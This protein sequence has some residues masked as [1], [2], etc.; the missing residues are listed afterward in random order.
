MSEKIFKSKVPSLHYMLGT[1]QFVIQQHAG[2]DT[3]RGGG[4]GGGRH[5]L[6]KFHSLGAWHTLFID[7]FYEMTLWG[8][9]NP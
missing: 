6:V 1:V 5:R 7:Y 9:E 3:V 8:G 4:G 2:V